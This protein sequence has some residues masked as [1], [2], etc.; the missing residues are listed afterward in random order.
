M[1]KVEIICGEAQRKIF[2]ARS[3]KRKIFSQIVY[4]KLGYVQ[5]SVEAIYQP[6]LHG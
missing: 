1:V 3:V 4:G 5:A 2:L 6:S